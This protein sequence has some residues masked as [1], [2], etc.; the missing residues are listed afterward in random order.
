MSKVLE[1][2]MQL[3]KPGDHVQNQSVLIFIELI[4]SLLRNLIVSNC[5]DLAMNN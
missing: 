1:W 2:S 3:I 4:R 5:I